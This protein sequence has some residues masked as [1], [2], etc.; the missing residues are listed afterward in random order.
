MKKKIESNTNLMIPQYIAIQHVLAMENL[1]GQRPVALTLGNWEYSVSQDDTDDIK[2][3]KFPNGVT[4]AVARGL[5][6]DKVKD[7]ER[8][9][10]DL[11]YVKEQLNLL[12]DAY[13]TLVL[14]REYVASMKP[15]DPSKAV[16]DKELRDLEFELENYEH[17]K[18]EYVKQIEDAKRL[19]AEIDARK[20][21]VIPEPEFYVFS[22]KEIQ[23]QLL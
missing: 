1:I 10:K 4:Y 20:I 15:N 17:F 11:E 23:A 9:V 2:V 22:Y 8:P 14:K 5:A 16:A 12:E 18:S 7:R 19:I 3:S 6:A 13:Q 21:P